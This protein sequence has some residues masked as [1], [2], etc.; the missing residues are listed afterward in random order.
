MNQLHL[1][2]RKDQFNPA[3]AFVKITKEWMVA[4]TSYVIGI[5]PTEDTFDEE[6][7]ERM[8]DEGI[9][10]HADDYKV[11]A[12]ADRVEWA[13][14]GLIIRTKT[15][16]KRPVLVEATTEEKEGDTFPQWER[17]VYDTEVP[18]EDVK[19][20]GIDGEK[21]VLLQKALGA[22]AL[23]LEFRGGGKGIMCYPMKDGSGVESKAY[24]MIMPVLQQ[25]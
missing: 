20:A 25:T 5:V 13:G 17:V 3:L 8:P 12:K 24:G 1:I 19:M 16:N 9:L 14:D 18:L 15:G 21:L 23:R 10:M 2:T 11:C 4:T 6:F 7:I 22:W